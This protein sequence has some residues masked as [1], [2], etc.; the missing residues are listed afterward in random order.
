MPGDRRERTLAI[1]AGIAIVIFLARLRLASQE[2]SADELYHVLAA[3]QWLLDGTLRVNG[4]AA[5]ERARG[6]T[7]A[8]AASMHLFGDG[9]LATRLPALLC[10][11][12]LPA[13][14]YAALCAAGHRVAAGWSALFV[15]LDPELVRLSAM[16]R[17]YAPQQLAFAV[18]AIAWFVAVEPG[19]S[20]RERIRASA[21]DRAARRDRDGPRDCI[22]RL[23]ALG[24]AAGALLV[25]DAL[26]EVTRIG[27]GALG[28]HALLVR[29]GGVVR[30]VRTRPWLAL[31]VLGVPLLALA[32]AVRLGIADDLRA[33]ASYVDYWARAAARD[34]RFYHG[35][36]IESWPTLWSLQAVA[37]LVAARA[38]PTIAVF[39][40]VV[41]FAGLGVHS[42]MAFK[43]PRFVSY[44]LPALFVPWGLAFAHLLPRFQAGVLDTL[45]AGALPRFVARRSGIAASLA[46]A[47][48]LVFVAF[49]NSGFVRSL[50]LLAADPS[51]RDSITSKGTLSWVRAA[52]ALHDEIGAA[53]VIVTTDDLKALHYLGR[54]DY[55]INLNHLYED[56]PL[57]G[58]PRPEFT[59]DPKTGLRLISRPESL[60]RIFSCHP[61][62]LLVAQTGFLAADWFV[63]PET[64]ASLLAHTEAVALPE[65]FG[66]TARRWN[67][68]TPTREDAPATGTSCPPETS[69]SPPSR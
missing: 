53:P 14:V 11:A 59:R 29:G 30:A 1:A 45:R 20:P 27:V 67:D 42:A 38:A 25:A 37:L 61:R 65:A 36:L 40:G 21:N 56:L 28:L 58:P 54:A 39:C 55:V 3:K 51:F 22:R 50:R 4:A 63:P 57:D 12:A 19:A 52:A 66:V 46:V 13:L 34:T 47:G 7:L 64:R 26:Q 68:D 8:V 18:G 35:W 15:A 41:F 5:Y 9:V 44:L 62:G 16:C 17:F 23:A 43:S 69:T 60:A 2:Y 48:A 10:G 32:I 49:A 33:Q 31:P 6:F 24:L